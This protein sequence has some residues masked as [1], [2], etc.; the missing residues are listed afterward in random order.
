MGKKRTTPQRKKSRGRR[1]AI[2]ALCALG[3]ILSAD[4]LRLHV[5]V[6]T[7]PAHDS[8]C[9]VG[10]GLNCETTAASDWSVFLGLPLAF[11]GIVAYGILALITLGGLGR[12]PPTRSWP[13][14]VL[15]V[16]AAFASLSGIALLAV[17]LFVI[18]SLCLVCVGTYLVSFA[19]LALSW[20]EVRAM[21]FTPMGAL[22]E[23]WRVARNRRDLLLVPAALAVL[24]VAIAAFALPAYWKVETFDGPEGLTAGRTWDGHHWVGASRPLVVIEEFSDYQCPYCQRGHAEMRALVKEH[25]DTI[26]LVHRDY[27]LDQACNPTIN[28][29]FHQAACAYARMARCAG[30][31]GVFWEAS[32]YLFSR[33]R[34]A[35]QVTYEEL[36]GAVGA[37]AEALRT[38][39]GE[40]ETQQALVA[41]LA[42]G[43][44]LGVRATP[45]F[46]LNGKV[47][48][49]RI[50][51]E[52]LAP[53]LGEEV[54]A[55]GEAATPVPGG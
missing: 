3:V 46:V 35:D 5:N 43:R 14:G 27:P 21:G 16:L 45:S 20:I 17:S 11:W 15:M 51:P 29:P 37:D 54:P 13:F 48:R 38:C 55:E 8:Y 49:G 44:G 9:D 12:R 41:D 42:Q 19:L 4:L 50:P 2:L 18:G 10:E 28:R 53:L 34:D 24:A 7:N 1:L 22:T 52:V 23:E 30:E 25:P 36:A 32:D 47:Y 26:R 40:P 31:Q 33:G 39:A 6:H